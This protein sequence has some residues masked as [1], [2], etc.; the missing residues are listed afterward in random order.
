M[1][2]A[3]RKDVERVF[4]VLQARFAVACGSARMWHFEHLNS[5]MMTCILLHH[6]I[7]EDQSAKDCG[8]ALAGVEARA[9]VHNVPVKEICGFSEFI[10]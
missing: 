5:I 4:G 8:K 2:E 7:V 10:E 1:Q 9:N 6:M 3:V